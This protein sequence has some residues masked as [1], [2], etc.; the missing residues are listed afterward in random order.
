MKKLLLI[1]FLLANAALSYSQISFS[2]LSTS[3]ITDTTASLN[4]YVNVNNCPNGG[5][6]HAQYSTSP[7]FATVMN[8]SGGGSSVS[9]ARTINIL[10]LT[11]G[12]TYYWRY[13]GYLGLNCNQS[14]V[15][16]LHRLLRQLIQFRLFQLFPI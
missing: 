1:L 8:A 5:S 15:F 2:A 9:F 7:S 11:P 6:F 3:N 10:G 13:Y 12:T 16:P 4:A 14:T